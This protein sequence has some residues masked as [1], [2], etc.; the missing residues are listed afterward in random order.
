MVP[1]RGLSFNFRDE[2]KTLSH[3]DGIWRRGRGKLRAHSKKGV[4]ANKIRYR[5]KN[6]D[7]EAKVSAHPCDDDSQSKWKG[8]PLLLSSSPSSL[9]YYYCINYKV[10]KSRAPAFRL[11]V[12]QPFYCF[13]LFSESEPL[14]FGNW[15]TASVIL[16]GWQVAPPPR[17]GDFLT[18][19]LATL[20]SCRRRRRSL[21]GCCRKIVYDRGG[22]Q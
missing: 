3:H 2:I 18:D 6:T 21:L 16:F 17:L 15:Y 11:R 13:V 7:F 5:K 20:P 4:K 9:F 19:G 22:E 10:H 12:C 14:G 1:R 8:T